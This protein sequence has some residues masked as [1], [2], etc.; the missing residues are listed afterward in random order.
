MEKFQC[1]FRIINIDIEELKNFQTKKIAGSANLN[2]AKKILA[3]DIF[4][5][6]VVE[7][8]DNF[9]MVLKK[10]LT[11]EPFDIMYEQK[12]VAKSNVIKNIIYK[13]IEEYGD[14]IVNNNHLD[15]QL[16]E[17][18]RNV[19]FKEEKDHYLNSSDATSFETQTT[20]RRI[21][22]DIVGKFYRNLYIGPIVNLIRHKNGLKVGGSY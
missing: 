17:F 22:R 13:E 1:L 19:L 18:V 16:Y 6:G 21:Q 9:L 7:E 8:F 11:P 12:N 15:V 4:L 14:K 2:T 20:V 10:K 5:V 3:E